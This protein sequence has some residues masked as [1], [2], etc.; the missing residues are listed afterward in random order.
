MQCRPNVLGHRFPLEK[1]VAI[2]KPQHFESLA[3][4]PGVAARI[5]LLVRRFIVLT[6]VELDDDAPIETDE[7]HNIISKRKLPPKL[8]S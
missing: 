6:T 4:Q 3:A 7:V 1:D 2:P 8:E 5:I